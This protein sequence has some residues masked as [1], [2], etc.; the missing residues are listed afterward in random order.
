MPFNVNKFMAQ[1]QFEDRILE[2][3]EKNED[4]TTSDIQGAVSVIV[5]EIMSW[6]EA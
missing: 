1:S 5:Q 2:L 3:I 6:K 4:F